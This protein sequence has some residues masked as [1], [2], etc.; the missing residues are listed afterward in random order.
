MGSGGLSYGLSANNIER[1]I[2][3]YMVKLTSIDASIFA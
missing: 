1:V 2:S 3:N